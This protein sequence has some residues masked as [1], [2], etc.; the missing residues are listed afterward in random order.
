VRRANGEGAKAQEH[1]DRRAVTP[2]FYKAATVVALTAN[3]QPPLVGPRTASAAARPT[4][5]S[6]PG[7]RVLL[8]ARPL[9]TPAKRE[10]AVP[11]RA[12]AAAIAAEWQAQGD[13]I[14]PSSMPLTRLVNSAIDGV[15]ERRTQVA[16]DISKYLASDLLCY[17]AAAPSALVQ[18]QAEGWDPILDW[19]QQTLGIR[20]RVTA[21]IVP[22]AQ[23]PEATAALAAWLEGLDVFALTAVHAMTSL[24][25]SALLARALAERRLE[26]AAAWAAAHID[27]DFQAEKW[28]VDHL[29]KARRDR[30]WHELEAASRLFNLSGRH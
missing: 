16:A 30:Q 12:L 26:A 2:R 17:R 28:G 14:D 9:K 1:G 4:P 29:A 7:Y 22:I 24:L 20:L 3:D 11:S 25:G 6:A 13:E 21:G 23:P 5:L 19:G 15:C 8:D 27:E 18:R 10:F